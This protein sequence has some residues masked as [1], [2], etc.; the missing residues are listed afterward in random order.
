MLIHRLMISVLA[1]AAIAVMPRAPANAQYCSFP[2]EWP[3][4]VAGAVVGTAATIATAPFRPYYYPYYPYYYGYYPAY[5]YY[6]YYRRHRYHR[7]HYY[8]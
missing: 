2:L 8:Y 5:S 1:A 7:H 4:C 3:F 6:P